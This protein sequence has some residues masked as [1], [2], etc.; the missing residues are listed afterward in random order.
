[1][2]IGTVR[3]VVDGERCQGHNRCR[4]LAPDLIEIDELGFARAKGDGRVPPDQ[5]EIARKAVRNCPEF[6]LRLD[7]TDE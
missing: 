3:L 6:A 5:T 7:A 1:M 2:S 4:M